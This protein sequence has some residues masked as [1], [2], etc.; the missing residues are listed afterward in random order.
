VPLAAFVTDHIRYISGY[1]DGTVGPD[2]SISRA[3]IAMIMFRLLAA[4]GK[5]IP[6]SGAFSDVA[7]GAWH[8]Q[9]VNYLASIGVVDGYGDTT[10]R[11]DA[12]ITRAEF[13]KILGG[14]DD[15]D[16]PLDGEPLSDISGHWAESDIRSAYAKGWIEGYPDGTFLPQRNLSRAD[17]VT[18]VNRILGRGIEIEDM[19][20]WA[21][22]YPD[23]PSSHWAYSDIIEASV[24]HDFTRKDNG[25]ELWVE[26]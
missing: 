25:S 1:P 2:R 6:V 3:E 5:D 19:P 12:P 9:A 23:L 10:F 15:S 17:C 13:V 7:D 21:P 16:A 22:S 24:T 14:F 4:Q 26:P 11:P 20:D 18:I 8:A